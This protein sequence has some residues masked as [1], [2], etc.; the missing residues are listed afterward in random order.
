M[1]SVLENHHSVTTFL[2][3]KE[4]RTN[5]LASL[6]RSDYR[7]CR[8]HIISN[9]LATDMAHHFEVSVCLSLSLYAHPYL[10]TLFKP[11]LGA[12]QV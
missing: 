4:A 7:E 12:R 3:L 11:T 6:S 1:Q 8:A 9:I 10:R 2:I 5:I